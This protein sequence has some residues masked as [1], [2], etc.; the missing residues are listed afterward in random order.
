MLD[1]DTVRTSAGGLAVTLAAGMS[2]YN[3]EGDDKTPMRSRHPG[4]VFV[5]MA[6]GAVRFLGNYIEK[7][8]VWNWD[9]N[10]NGLTGNNPARLLC[11]QRLC[12]S[13]DGLVLDSNKY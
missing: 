1:C 13:Q 11:W 2:C 3:G 7:T 8:T 12:L 5:T 9:T 10:L 6:D 4:G